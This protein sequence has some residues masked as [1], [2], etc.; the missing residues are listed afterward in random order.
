MFFNV[1]LVLI[2][3]LTNP[4]DQNPKTSKIHIFS[5]F[6]QE[7]TELAERFKIS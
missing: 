7:E 1:L 6:R 2:K 3:K 5:R 4:L